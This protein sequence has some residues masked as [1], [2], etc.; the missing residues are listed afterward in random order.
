ML[1]LFSTGGGTISDF[2]VSPNGQYVAV[3]SVPNVAS[4]V[5]DGY[6]ADE[7]STSVTTIIVDL[8]TGAVVRSMQGFRLSW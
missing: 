4:S 5:S 8:D 6:F 7:R 2:E 3:E 1:Q